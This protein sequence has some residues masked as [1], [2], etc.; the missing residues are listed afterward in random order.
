MLSIDDE[1]LLTG[2]EKTEQEHPS[3]QK[4]VDGSRTIHTSRGFPLP[5]NGRWGQPLLCD[6][7]QATHCWDGKSQGNIQPNIY[8]APEVLFD[9]P[10]GFSADIWNV[11]AMVVGSRGS[12]FLRTNRLQIWDGMSSKTS[13]CSMRSM[14]TGNTPRRIMSPKLWRTWDNRR[15]TFSG[16]AKKRAMFLTRTV[17]FAFLARMR[18]ISS[19]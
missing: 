4:T 10:W 1:T 13:T 6:L 7:G 16:A 9:M 19:R 18:L 2:F 15:F 11:G 14:K 17:G 12:K 3:P 8:K 5:R